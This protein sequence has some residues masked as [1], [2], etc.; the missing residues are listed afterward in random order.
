[1]DKLLNPKQVRASQEKVLVLNEDYVQ[2]KF[3]MLAL[4]V[5]SLSLRSGTRIYFCRKGA[6]IVFGWA[7]D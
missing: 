3:P 5:A 4:P 7:R 2:A 1:M 6:Y